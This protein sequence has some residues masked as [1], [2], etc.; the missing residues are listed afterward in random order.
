MAN[1]FL[2]T[3]RLGE[4]YLNGGGS[5]YI[6]KNVNPDNLPGLDYGGLLGKILTVD[7]PEALRLSL[8]ATGTLRAGSY[9]RVKTKA[10]SS[11]A[12]AK[13]IACFWDTQANNGFG[14]AI[15]TPDISATL[16]GSV[17]GIYVDAPAKGNYCWIQI[18]GLATLQVRAA[19]TSGVAGNIAV[20]T[21]LTTNTFDGIADATD[22]FATA[23][24]Y[25]TLIGKWWETPAS[26]A[27]NLAFLLNIS[28]PY[29][30]G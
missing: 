18:G 11:A 28:N 19:V 12:P 17:A 2:N 4:G 5:A 25:K 6:G 8:T 23:G 24:A 20:F 26:G 14:N 13:G 27:L 30:I 3:V 29:L 9:M 22:Y 1:P 21:G 7:D 10:A 16:I 15:V